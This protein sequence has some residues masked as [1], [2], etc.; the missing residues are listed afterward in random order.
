M[1]RLITN[2]S[3]AHYEISEQQAKD[4]QAAILSNKKL[5]K[6]E[7]IG[8]DIE[9]LYLQISSVVVIVK[10]QN[11]TPKINE[12]MLEMSELNTLTMSSLPD[13]ISVKELDIIE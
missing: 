7:N 13:V 5:I 4:I 11:T 9:F 12:A 1:Y 2:N 8:T 3:M 10:Q 6:L